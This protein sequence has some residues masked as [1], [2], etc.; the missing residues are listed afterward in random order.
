M[1]WREQGS[2]K[3]PASFRRRRRLVICV[4]GVVAIAV[5]TLFS[6]G[7]V[8]WWARQMAARQIDAWAISETRQWLAWAAWADTGDG[9]VDLMEAVCHRRLEQMDRWRRALQSA[10]QKGAPDAGIQHE[11]E[12]GLIR[13]GLFP[14]GVETR[15]GELAEAALSPHDVAESF[16]HGYLARKEQDKARAF[17]EGWEANYPNEAH[18]AHLWGIYRQSLGQSDRA[19]TQFKHAVAMQPRHESARTAICELFESQNRLDEAFD[20]YVELVTRLP[21]SERGRLGL[22]R[23]LRKLGRTGDARAVLDPLISDSEPPAKV[24]AEVRRV[25]FESGNYLEAEQWFRPANLE[26]ENDKDTLSSEATMLALTG[27]SVR[28]ELLFREITAKINA[29]TRMYDLERQLVVDPNDKLAADELKLLSVALITVSD[30]LVAA[31]KKQTT[32]QGGQSLALSGPE[33]F[34]RHCSACHG[35]GGDGNGR[36]A[37]HLFPR[38]RD[39]RN[40]KFRLVSTRNGVPTLDDLGAAIKLGMPGTS[41]RPYDEVSENQRGLL[42]E[43]VLRHHR[44]GIH[45]HFIDMLKREGE[46]VDEDEVREV[47]ANCTTPGEVIEP[48]RI[49]SSDSQSIARGK[50]IYTELGCNKCHGDNGLGSR[51]VFLVDEKTRPARPRDLVYERFKGGQEPES[52]Y[53]RIAAGMPGSPHPATRDLA[54]YQLIDLVQYCLSLAQEPKRALTNHQQA[55]LTTSRRYLSAFGGSPSPR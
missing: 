28:A 32:E 15:L 23:V 42:A 34:A 13:S 30:N 16:V 47:V 14:K 50:D 26:H 11:R 52:I 29:S 19:M 12:L 21:M 4:A 35:T 10:E 55:T 54:Q 1:D 41:M 24:V 5:L 43:E 39:F 45:D 18:V 9:N 7:I 33:L 6:R 3:P 31:S 49:G 20:Q 27:D 37:R 2:Q 46:A 22:S 53:L 17:I 40:G 38:P 44:E 48:P 8:G 25:E 51:D 36:A